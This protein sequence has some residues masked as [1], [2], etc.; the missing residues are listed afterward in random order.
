MKHIGIIGFGN[1]GEAIAAGLRRSGRDIEISVLEPVEQKRRTAVERYRAR[2]VD[3]PIELFESADITVLAIKP[4]ILPGFVSSLDEAAAG[5]RFVSVAAGIPLEY[6]RKALGTREIVR[7]MPNLAATVGKALV[8]IAW[9]EPID[10]TTLD[11][12]FD[13]ADAIGDRLVVPERLMSAVT[14]VSGSGIAYVFALAHAMALGGTQA[15]LPY[16]D[17]LSAAV[18]TIGGAA[19]L[20]AAGSTH[21]IELLSRVTSPAGTTIEGVAELEAGGFTAAVMRA[22]KAASMRAGELERL[23]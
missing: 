16:Q 15:G 2:A 20:L 6:Y 7:F 17:A 11:Y 1:M 10:R 21:P 18:S 12:A 14:G 9:D 13:I 8:A 22:V 5:L 3:H 23:T 19:E 4:Q